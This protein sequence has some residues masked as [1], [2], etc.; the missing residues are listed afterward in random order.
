MCVRGV[1][2]GVQPVEGRREG[3]KRRPDRGQV[4]RERE[5]RGQVG[6][7]EGVGA[8]YLCDNQLEVVVLAYFLSKLPGHIFLQAL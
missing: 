5:R 6:K 1:N 7:E 4:V 3:C 8:G 2:L